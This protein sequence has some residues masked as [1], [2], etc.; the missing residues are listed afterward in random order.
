MKVIE[1]NFDGH[2]FRSRTEARWAVFFKAAGILYEYEKEGLVLDGDPYLPDFW[3]P[4]LEL[5]LEVK[6][7]QPTPEE[8]S[9]CARLAA[10]SGYGVMLAVGAPNPKEQIFWLPPNPTSDDPLASAQY[11]LADDR[12]NEN[13]FWLIA[14]DTAWFSIGPV[15]GPDHG[16][17][18]LVHTATKAGYDAARSARFEHGES[19]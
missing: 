15:T 14:D 19:G 11:Y 18:P 6:G 3:L 13:E 9:L 4:D 2:R 1:T 16:K 5:W 12:R 17:H 8:Y 10:T 7:D